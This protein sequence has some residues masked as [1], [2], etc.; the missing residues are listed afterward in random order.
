MDI[1]I[2]NSL[3]Y[4]HGVTQTAA[5]SSRYKLILACMDGEDGLMLNL[6]GTDSTLIA[7]QA[8]KPRSN[9]WIRKQERREKA[10]VCYS[11]TLLFSNML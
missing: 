10:L 8:S 2:C 11:L 5:L 6:A 4:L 9:P 3:E 7:I 1:L